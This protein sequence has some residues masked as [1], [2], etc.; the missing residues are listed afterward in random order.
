MIPFKNHLS[1]KEQLMKMAN[2]TRRSKDDPMTFDD[3]SREFEKD[4]AGENWR[5]KA[6]AFCKRWRPAES[7]SENVSKIHCIIDTCC[8]G[9]N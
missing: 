8:V 1:G 4:E 5:A 6:V 7:E 9:M 2:S 3:W